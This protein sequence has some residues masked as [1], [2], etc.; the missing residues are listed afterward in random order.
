MTSIAP[1]TG[2]P[3]SVTFVVEAPAGAVLHLVGE[4]V[5]GEEVRQQGGFESQCPKHQGD[6]NV[7]VGSLEDLDGIT[8]L[9]LSG[10]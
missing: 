2:S 8:G 9:D 7:V 10:V 5:G 6:G 4:C 3:H 1:D